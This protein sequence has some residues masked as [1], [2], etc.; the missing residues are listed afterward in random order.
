[1]SHVAVKL[2]LATG[3]AISTDSLEPRPAKPAPIQAPNI[4]TELP[5]WLALVARDVVVTWGFPPNPLCIAL[6]ERFRDAGF[7]PWW[8]AADYGLARTRYIAREGQHATRAYFD[9][10]IQRLQ[11]AK[12]QLDAIYNN[13]SIETLT[14]AGY[15]AV[16][17]IYQTI[18]AN[19][20][21]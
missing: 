8:F 20:L 18:T 4:S 10:Q 16:E 3:C 14:Q 17:Q 6:I 13:H 5:R 15:Q 19:I 7:T 1:M 12:T 11:Q 9:P 2:T 21:P